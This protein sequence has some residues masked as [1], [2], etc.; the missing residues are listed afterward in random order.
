MI[1]VSTVRF[2]IRL[3]KRAN[4]RADKKGN[5]AA[6]TLIIGA[7]QAGI[8]T[9]H[10]LEQNRQLRLEPVAFIDDDFSKTGM[11]LRG[12]PILGTREDIP[13]SIN[14]NR[15]EK[16]IIAMPSV[17]GNEIRKI[18]NIC[19]PFE[20]EVLTL[21][22]LY[23]IID[24]K[25]N[26]QK[27]RKIQIED[28]LRRAP[29]QTNL[30]N[31]HSTITGKKVLVTGAGGSIGGELCR[32]IIK[33]DPSEIVLV[34]H[35]ENSIFEI[36][37]EL[38]AK[39][40]NNTDLQPVLADIRT[41][42]RISNILVHY[43][44]DVVFH[45]AA[46]KHV[47]LM[48][49]NPI[50][51]V[52]NN[53]IGTKNLVDALIKTGINNFVMISTDKAV[54]PTNIMGLSK[55]IAEIIVMDAAYNADRNFKVVRFGNVLGSRGSVVN[56]FKK[57]IVNGGPLTLTH[58][59]IERYFMTIPEA[60]Q[61]VLQTSVIGNGGEIFVLDMGKPVRILDLAKDMISLSGLEEDVDIKIEYTGL[62]PGEKMYEELFNKGEELELTEHSKI[63]KA[64]NVVKHLPVELEC[65]INN[66]TD[67]DYSKTDNEIVDEIKTFY[68][69]AQALL[70]K[71][72]VNVGSNGYN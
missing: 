39:R 71:A 12:L 40:K 52:T 16:I 33:G 72:D 47:P 43:K 27:L 69:E 4:E 24:G 32:Q 6:R 26:V 41:K 50:E 3:F 31:I 5:N 66:F 29:I 63:M 8:M 14:E 10:E 17:S 37:E 49:S 54:N 30:E 19:E 68:K 44:P 55:R 1:L 42:E 60:V 51:A 25:V 9:V 61:L 22:G 65:R 64:T 59:E 11:K 21:P 13:K 2:S 58:P 62:R 48:E 67:F 53:V 46:H 45:A 34:G 20:K 56:T 36:L 18:I 23:D 28:L 7:G 15:I 38:K 57:Q 35:G 70:N